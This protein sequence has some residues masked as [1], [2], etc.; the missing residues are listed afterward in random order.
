M[1]G[2]TGWVE[3]VL[4]PNFRQLTI[5]LAPDEEGEVV[6]TLVHHKKPGI[7]GSFIQAG[8][9]LFGVDVL[10]VH[11]WNDYYFNHETAEYFSQLGAKF[12]AVD[13][14]KYGRSLRDHQTPGFVR[15]LSEHFEDID[16]VIDVIQKEGGK[17]WMEPSA[18]RRS[19]LVMGHSAGALI[20]AMWLKSRPGI[21]HGFIM[22]GP[23]LEFQAHSLGRTLIGPLLEFTEFLSPNDTLPR[24]SF[25]Q[26][27]RVISQEYGGEWDYNTD[28][29]PHLSF[30]TP[31][32][33]LRS[34][35]N[36][37]KMVDQGLDLDMPMLVLLS[38]RTIMK[39]LWDEEKRKAD[40]AIDVDL[41]ARR[42][43]K[44]GDNVQVA[45]I[46]DALHE[47]FLSAKPVRDHA[48]RVMTDWLIGLYR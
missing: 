4:G 8:R 39:P 40:T 11:G 6:A 42:A 36:A 23:W 1:T 3:D 41:M 45:K 17:G 48:Y 10:Y 15:D 2:A 12:Y 34:V 27:G 21:A 14:R 30:A 44:M 26:Y 7:I 22:N 35:L 32:P 31:I 47:V 28:W 5:P 29:K 25:S 46:P 16:A 37:H 20:L 43:L 33:W 9:P 24:I 18:P 19:L 38:N 13:L